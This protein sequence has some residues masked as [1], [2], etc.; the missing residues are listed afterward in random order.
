[1]LPLKNVNYDMITYSCLQSTPVFYGHVRVNI[2]YGYRYL[3]KYSTLNDN[4]VHGTGPEA[5]I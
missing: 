3:S 2:T 4:P 1:M 5:A